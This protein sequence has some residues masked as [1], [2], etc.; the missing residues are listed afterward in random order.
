MS[1]LQPEN[2]EFNASSHQSVTEWLERVKDGD[3]DAAQNLWDRY[4]GQLI[5]LAARKLGQST[6]I[7]DEQDAVVVAFHDFLH[8]VSDRRFSRL[9]DRHDLWQILAM[10]TDRR[11]I[12][13]KRRTG[14]RVQGTITGESPLSGSGSPG[15]NPLN[16][17]RCPGPTPEEAMIA[18]DQLQRLFQSLEV[19]TTEAKSEHKRLVAEQ[20]KLIA[21]QKLRGCTNEEIAAQLDIDPTTVGRR[22]DSIRVEMEQALNHE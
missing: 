22:L 21:I 18:A 6:G 5:R 10:L 15:S 8:G 4:V 1:N 19:E 17:I 16:Q 2:T 14:S 7:E 3:D 9:N 11:I 12:D 20:K 13:Q